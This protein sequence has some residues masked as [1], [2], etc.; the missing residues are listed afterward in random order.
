[1]L[2]RMQHEATLRLTASNS[3][4]VGLQLPETH[5][6]APLQNN[7]EALMTSGETDGQPEREQL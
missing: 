4:A 3:L 5:Q 7:C 6:R 2:Q 1:M